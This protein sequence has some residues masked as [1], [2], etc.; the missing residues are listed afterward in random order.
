MKTFDLATSRKKRKNHVVNII[1]LGI[2]YS[3]GYWLGKRYETGHSPYMIAYAVPSLVSGLVFCKRFPDKVWMK[4]HPGSI[5][6]VNVYHYH[7][8]DGWDP[9]LAIVA[10]F[11][12]YVFYM[13]VGFI[14]FPAYSCW[15]VIAILWLTVSIYRHRHEQCGMNEYSY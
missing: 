13:F 1:V 11:L 8:S 6:R 2:L 14:I 15:A 10:T 5:G 9:A 3:V 7:Y 4:L 12:K